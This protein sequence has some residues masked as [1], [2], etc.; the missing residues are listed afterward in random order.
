MLEAIKTTG[1]FIA[2]AIILVI[3]LAMFF[4]KPVITITR[5]AITSL[6]VITTAPF[7]FISTVIS[8]VRLEYVFQ[9][10]SMFLMFGIETSLR[11]RT[12]MTKSYYLI[13]IIAI[14]PFVLLLALLVALYKDL[15][16]KSFSNMKRAHFLIKKQLKQK[17]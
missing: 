3:K 15:I 10:Y 9:K 12:N 14:T 11:S 13:W 5:Y 8:T 16:G 1:I 7:V 2:V 6:L 17:H 4:I